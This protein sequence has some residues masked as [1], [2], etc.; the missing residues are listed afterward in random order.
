LRGCSIFSM[1]SNW[2]LEPNFLYRNASSRASSRSLMACRDI[3]C[4]CAKAAG[5]RPKRTSKKIYEYA[6]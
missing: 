6:P 4:G 3:C 2:S 1:G 5:I